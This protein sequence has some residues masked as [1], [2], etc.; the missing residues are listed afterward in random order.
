MPLF[1]KWYKSMPCHGMLL[2][3]T[4]WNKSPSHLVMYISFI[5]HVIILITLILIIF[6]IKWNNY[7]RKLSLLTGSTDFFL[8]SVNENFLIDVLTINLKLPINIINT[9]IY[10]WLTEWL[11]DWMMLFLRIA[12]Y[13]LTNKFSESRLCRV[14]LYWVCTWR[15]RPFDVCK[16][17]DGG[18]TVVG[19]GKAGTERGAWGED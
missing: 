8:S 7:M 5:M 2:T 10:D 12:S 15:R 1:N 11:T 9:V 6:I 19:T 13:C 3:P 4:S 14:V 17:S 16:S 18:G